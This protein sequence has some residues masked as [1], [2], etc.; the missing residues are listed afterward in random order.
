MQGGGAKKRD[1][2]VAPG[3]LVVRLILEKCQNCGIA[4]KLIC[5]NLYLETFHD[6]I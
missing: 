4:Q 5:S 3:P 1:Y 6:W 2:C